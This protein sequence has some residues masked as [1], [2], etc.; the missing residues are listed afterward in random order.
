LRAFRAL[1]RSLFAVFVHP[2]KKAPDTKAPYPLLAT[3]N[4]DMINVVDVHVLAVVIHFAL[5]TFSLSSF[6]TGAV[7]YSSGLQ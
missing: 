3:A 7:G 5:V 6:L 4:G 2:S 1:C